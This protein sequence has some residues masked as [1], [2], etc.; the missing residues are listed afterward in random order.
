MDDVFDARRRVTLLAKDGDVATCL[1]Y[2]AATVVGGLTLVVAG[3]ALGRR[4]AP[5]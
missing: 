5:P 3:D 2:L 4:M 1:A